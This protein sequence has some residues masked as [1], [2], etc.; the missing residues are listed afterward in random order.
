[1]T[2]SYRNSM[3]LCQSLPCTVHQDVL[4]WILVHKVG[5]VQSLAGQ[6]YHWIKN[7]L[8]EITPTMYVCGC[9]EFLLLCRH[10]INSNTAVC[11]SHNNIFN[12]YNTW[13]LFVCAMLGLELAPYS[14][15]IDNYYTSIGIII[16]MKSRVC[17]HVHASVSF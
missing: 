16:I 8:L 12:H 3:F 2:L 14:F 13:S 4:T 9:E 11:N 1:M 10:R 15:S 5:V 6:Q 17:A 7:V